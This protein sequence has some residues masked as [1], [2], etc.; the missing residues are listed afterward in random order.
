M[1]ELD[2]L[3]LKAEREKRKQ[4]PITISFD[5]GSTAYLFR[6]SYKHVTQA[7]ISK[8]PDANCELKQYMLHSPLAGTT[9]EI[10]LTGLSVGA[11]LV[12]RKY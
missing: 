9:I 5:P 12:G 6:T 4:H 8:F 11:G 3:G 10:V 1:S 2:L 7:F